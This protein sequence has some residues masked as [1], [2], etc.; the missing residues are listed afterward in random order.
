MLLTLSEIENIQIIYII[1][2]ISL[3]VMDIA[4]ADV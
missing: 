4:A 1:I 2:I 3:T